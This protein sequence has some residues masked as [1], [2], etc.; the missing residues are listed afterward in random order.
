MSV[1]WRVGKGP[2]HRQPDLRNKRVGHKK[3]RGWSSPN[4][5]GRILRRKGTAVR[6]PTHPKMRCLIKS[7]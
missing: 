2:K 7:Q 5:I 6:N 4:L 1:L 3:G